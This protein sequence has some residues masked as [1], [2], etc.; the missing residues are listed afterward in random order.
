VSL[1][2]NFRRK[3]IQNRLKANFEVKNSE[4]LAYS[5]PYEN[6]NTLADIL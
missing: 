6:D 1:N 5:S 3:G 2:K 4:K